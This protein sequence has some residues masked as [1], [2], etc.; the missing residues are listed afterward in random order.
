M[1]FLRDEQV[2]QLLGISIGG[3]RNKIRNGDPLPPH[4]RLPGMRV[5]LWPVDRVGEWVSGY[6]VGA[7]GVSTT[8]DPRRRGR[9]S[10]YRGEK[11]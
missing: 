9:P 2:A 5:R 3:L 11:K 10:K 8:P 6:E 4:C 7:S 1:T